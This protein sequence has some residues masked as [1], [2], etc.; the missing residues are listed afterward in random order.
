MI[1]TLS[2]GA[3]APGNYVEGRHSGHILD[4]VRTGSWVK[5]TLR[6]GAQWVTR[7]S[8]KVTVIL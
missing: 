2:Y 1:T 8:V 6:N 7:A 5:V 4:V 3:L